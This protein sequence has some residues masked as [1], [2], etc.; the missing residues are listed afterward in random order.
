MNRMTIMNLQSSSGQY[1]IPTINNEYAKQQVI[2]AIRSAWDKFSFID[3]YGR[4]WINSDGCHTIL[5]TTRDNALYLVGRLSDSEKFNANAMIFIKG[6]AICKILDEFCYSAGS[7][8]RENYIRY[9]Q[10]VYEAI[11]HSSKA[12]ELR[13]QNYERIRSQICGLKSKRIKQFNISNDELTGDLLFENAQF[14]HIR[15]V[16]AFPELSMQVNNGL[17]I[18]QSTHEQITGLGI[19]DEIELQE[20]CQRNGWSIDWLHPYRE[21]LGAQS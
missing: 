7:L 2:T 9:S 21:F 6:P 11:K 20:F 17:I 8:S 4:I 16:A 10:C 15:S 5:R 13:A 14:S 19:S 1:D 12:R 18:N 3:C